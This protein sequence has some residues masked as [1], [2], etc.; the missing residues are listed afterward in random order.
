[1][2]AGTAL[3]RRRGLLGGGAAAGL[4]ATA[5]ALVALN[6]T[7]TS[8]EPLPPA[9]IGAPEPSTDPTCSPQMRREPIDARIFLRQDI[10]D[11]QRLDLRDALQSYPPVRR[12]TFAGHDEAYARFR[13][14]YRDNPDL[15]G[16]V[17]PE[18]LPESFQVELVR[19][20]DYARLAAKFRDASGV[21]QIAAN[22]CAYR[23]GSG[24]GE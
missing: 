3:R 1:M 16:S 21:D 22:P 12:V 10:T 13:K 20:A 11:Q 8:R 5:A 6:L 14:S 9:A 2:V 24:E 7:P 15:V 17:E 4:V 18:Q 23:T 19:T